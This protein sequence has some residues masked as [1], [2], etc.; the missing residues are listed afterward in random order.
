MI[1]A[2]LSGKGGTGKTTVA[3][4]LAFSLAKRGKKVLLVDADVEEPNAGLYLRPEITEARAVTVPTPEVKPE[5]CSSCGTCAEFCQFHALAV[6]PGNVLVFPELC[7]GCGGCAL[8]CPEDAVR[9][10]PREIGVVEKGR[11]GECEFWQGKL[12]VGEPF[13]IPVTRQLKSGLPGLPGETVVIVDSPPGASCPVIEAVRGSDFAILVTEPS[14]F[15]RHDLEIALKLVREL[16]VGHGVV[17][18][19]AERDDSLIEEFCRAREVPVL[20]KIPFSTRIA[21]LGARGILFARA[22][23]YW[24]DKFFDLYKKIEE[25]C[26]CA[27]S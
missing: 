15:G 23:P 14:P 1:V 24:E 20:L 13:P 17:V 25:S 2:V 22:I 10:I 8:V 16:G 21:A 26:P 27:S 5:R 12:K 11:A 7:H 18:N 9:E 3:V 19:R 4:N 6:V